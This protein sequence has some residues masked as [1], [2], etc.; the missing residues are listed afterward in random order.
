MKEKLISAEQIIDK[1]YSNDNKYYGLYVLSCYGLLTKFEDYIE[2]ID[3]IFSNCTFN[4]TDK[5]IA[6]LLSDLEEDIPDDYIETD[7]EY[8][9]GISDIGIGYYIEDGKP[10]SYKDHDP[11]IYLTTKY[12]NSLLLDTTIH[13]LSHII[14]SRIN[15]VSMDDDENIIERCGLRLITTTKDGVE[16][17]DNHL[18]DEVI[19]VLQ[20]HDILLNIK[21]LDT[22]IMDSSIKEFYNT[23]EK[24]KLE[25]PNGYEVGIILLKP[26]WEN[27]NFKSLVESNI[28]EGNIQSI[29]NEFNSI[30]ETDN[31]FSSFSLALDMVFDSESYNEYEILE[32]G[33][34]IDSIVKLY[35][36]KTNSYKK[37]KRKIKIFSKK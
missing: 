5:S 37:K 8:L 16:I 9:E 20:V 22:S 27:P 19:N 13:E 6:E 34:Y 4:I 11:I 15:V 7:T 24:K 3:D 26:L 36:L 31:A 14:K 12:G 23:L 30:I 33:I 21:N 10:I 18:L 28:V 17:W 2:I 25:E 29:E 1:Y 32:R 35:N